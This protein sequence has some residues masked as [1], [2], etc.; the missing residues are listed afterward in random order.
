MKL[1]FMGLY[2]GDYEYSDNDGECISYF[3]LVPSKECLEMFPNF[4]SATLLKNNFITFNLDHCI[5]VDG[6]KID[7]ENNDNTLIFRIVIDKAHLEDI[8]PPEFAEV[9]ER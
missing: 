6:I 7:D 8:L 9:E 2:L 5:Y 4:P 3:G 1:E